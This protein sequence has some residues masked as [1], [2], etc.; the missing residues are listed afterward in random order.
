MNT[1]HDVKVPSGFE[2]ESAALHP[3]V[4]ERSGMRARLE[5]LKSR[6]LVKVQSVRG[7]VGER[8]IAVRDRAKSQVTKVQSSM[9]SKPMLW[10]GIAAGAGFGIGLIGRFAQLRS[11]QR[12][13]LPDLIII[14]TGC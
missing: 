5:S 14:E 4:S 13:M 3:P 9:S 12:H 8:G 7:K 11:K 10:A 2:V 6:S 1:T